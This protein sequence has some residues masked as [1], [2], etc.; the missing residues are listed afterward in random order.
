MEAFR[1]LDVG[2]VGPRARPVVAA[3][4]P[5]GREDAEME[6]PAG[7]DVDVASDASDDGHVRLAG[8]GTLRSLKKAADRNAKRWEKEVANLQEE[9]MGIKKA[10]YAEE[11]LRHTVAL[12]AYNAVISLSPG[13]F[14]LNRR[15]ILKF[16]NELAD[17]P[18]EAEERAAER[19]REVEA[20]EAAASESEASEEEDLRERLEELRR[21][22][23]AEKK[24][25]EEAEKKKKEE[26]EKK[27]KQEDERKRKEAERRRAEAS[28]RDEDD[29]D[30]DDEEEEEDEEEAEER[31][32][33]R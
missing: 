26:A 32:A 25:K 14:A 31:A 22:R 20:R 8:G 29:D 21:K 7:D 19:E 27:K 30:D 5:G 16:L 2:R 11:S 24:K 10:K 33:S 23:R 6:E 28:R 4:G 1:F 13:Q 18:T 12:S 15:K 3:C 17:L 9:V